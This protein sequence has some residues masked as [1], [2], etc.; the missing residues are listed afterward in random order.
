MRGGKEIPILTV[1]TGYFNNNLEFSTLILYHDT[2][3]FLYIQSYA[4]QAFSSSVES[5]MVMADTDISHYYP[6][7]RNIL[8]L[9]C[10]Q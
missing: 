2:Y 5:V 9:H 8:D 1:L 10:H 6:Y 3:V 4:F 7:Q